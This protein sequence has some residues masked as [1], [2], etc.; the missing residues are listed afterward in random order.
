MRGASVNATTC[1]RR[2]LVVCM[3]GVILTLLLALVPRGAAQHDNK[4]D[5][6]V[7]QTLGAVYIVG[8]KS[9]VEVFQFAN[10]QAIEGLTIVTRDRS[11]SK[12][13]ANC[14]EMLGF[15]A[16]KDDMHIFEDYVRTSESEEIGQP[17]R[18]AIY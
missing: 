9:P 1:F 15:V 10:K 11:Q 3:I 18:D 5:L 17:E 2:I 16:S 7:P 12:Y 8:S 13:H 4:Q 14:I 6:S